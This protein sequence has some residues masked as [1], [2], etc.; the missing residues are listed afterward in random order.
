MDMHADDKFT[1]AFDYASGATA[2][3]VQNPLWRFTEIFTGSKLRE[4]VDIV[5]AFGNRIVDN[6][7][8]DREKGP[9][10]TATGTLDDEKLDEISGSLIQSLL[11]SIGDKQMVADAALN[12]LS[13]GK[14]E[15]LQKKPRSDPNILSVCTSLLLTIFNSTGRDTTAQALT[16]TFHLLMQHRY[17]YAKVRREVH[18]L[19]KSHH[20]QQ[21]TATST[22][23]NDS[24]NLPFNPTLFTPASLPYTHAVFNEAL[25]LHPPIPIEIKQA[26]SP[27]T[28][29]DKTFLPAGC[30]IVWCPWAMNRS[31]MTW[32]EDADHFRPERWLAPATTPRHPQQDNNPNT[33][34][35]M[36]INKSAAD[37]PVFNGGSRLCLGKKMAELVAVQVIA[38]VAW[39]FDFV[40]AY[41]GTERRSKSSLTLPMQG[42]L[43]VF[44]KVRNRGLPDVDEDMDMGY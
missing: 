8:E 18:D 2:E 35:T 5:K 30:I 9:I 36:V 10:S 44:V 32:G 23:G 19:I 24:N 42:G 16:W 26:L 29:P 12:Y 28:L 1:V 34:N 7:V 13:A 15:L 20:Q 6:A 37:F 39:T 22:A 43:P 4:S 17:V 33:P 38:S 31:K 3:R 25:R 40:P 14:R 21:L 41:E 11:D 27:T